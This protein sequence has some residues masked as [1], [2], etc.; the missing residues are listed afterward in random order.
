[1]KWTKFGT[2]SLFSVHF[3]SDGFKIIF[4]IFKTKTLHQIVDTC[5]STLGEVVMKY[6]AYT[7]ENFIFKTYNVSFKI[8]KVREHIDIP[9]KVFIHF[10]K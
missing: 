8:A 7:V 4:F 5:V 10:G 2:L 6:V 1:M 3:V 9:K